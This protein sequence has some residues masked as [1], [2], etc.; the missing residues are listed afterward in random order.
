[1]Y[2]LKYRPQTLSEIDNAER[3]ALLEKVFAKNK[4]IPH[5]FLLVGPRGTGKTSTARIIAKIL[6]CKNNVFAGKSKSP[7][8]CLSCSSCHDIAIG[9]FLDVYELDAASNRG[10]D[11]VRALRNQVNYVPVK[12]RQKVYII[13]EVHMLTKDAFNALLKTLEEPPKFV[14]FIL[15]TTEPQKLPET[16]VSRCITLNFKKA[17]IKELVASLKRIV[18]GEKLKVDE[19]VLTAVAKKANGSYRDAAKLLELSVQSTSLSLEE[20]ERVLSQNTDL[21]ASDLLEIVA[22]KKQQQALSWL[23]QFSE[24]G[25]AA[26]YLIESLLEILHDLLLFRKGVLEKGDYE[27]YKSLTL[28]QLARLIKLLLEAYQETKYTPVDILPLMI[29]VVEFTSN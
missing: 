26:N 3:R 11:D 24:Q 7:E 10:I 27:R 8:P 1:M 15:A 13:D 23:H 12:G 6:N 19:A 25:G 16:I 18:K 17:T 9:N 20:V 4:D 22:N 2:Y 14:T 28:P 21:S 5:A 29:A